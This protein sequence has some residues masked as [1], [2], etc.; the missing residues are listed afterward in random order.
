[1]KLPK[2]TKPM[3]W[4]GV[5]G[6]IVA[7]TLGFT[8]GGWVTGGTA[9]KDASLAAHNATV[10]VMAPLCAERFRAQN[11]SAARMADLAKAGTWERGSIVEK[12]GFAMVP[13]GKSSDTDIARACADI[14]LAPPKT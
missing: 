10:V 12:S 8:W 1:M 6:A 4:G 5:I 11:D 9:R 13:G 2:D 14:L 3:I 7:T